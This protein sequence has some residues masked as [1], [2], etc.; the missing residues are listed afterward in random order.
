MAGTA[1]NAT[2]IGDT[3]LL[4]NK[5]GTFGS[6]LNTLNYVVQ[7]GVGDIVSFPPGVCGTDC[8]TVDIEASSVLIQY[9]ANNF[10]SAAD[11]NGLAIT[12]LD[13]IGGPGIVTDLTTDTNFAGWTDD[14]ATFG[15]DWVAFNWESLSFTTDTFFN[16]ELTTVH[17]P[18]PTTLA[19]MTLGIAGVGY[20]RKKRA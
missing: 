8:Y 4:E 5:F 19:L 11:F 20:S 17:V 3:V 2:L 12:D 15:D 13:W 10:W 7:E 18:E 16:V 14:R 6:T 9:I 1:A